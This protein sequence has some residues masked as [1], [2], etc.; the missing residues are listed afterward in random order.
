MEC[1]GKWQVG[2][3]YASW[4]KYESF[5]YVC[6]VC[7]TRAMDLQL[8]KRACF[9]VFEAKAIKSRTFS[10][11]ARLATVSVGQICVVFIH[12]KA[13][14]EG[15][16]KKCPRSFEWPA[17]CH[18]TLS[19]LTVAGHFLATVLR[20]RLRVC[21]QQSWSKAIIWRS[22][23]PKL[24]LGKVWEY[25][26]VH[27]LKM[28]CTSSSSISLQNTRWSYSHALSM[29]SFETLNTCQHPPFWLI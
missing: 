10:W 20:H 28:L 4:F 29:Q 23:K 13:D 12:D 19:C 8:L 5:W 2:R 27:T 26:L 7:V 9:H 22:C 21:V 1:G 3:W 11:F 15:F 25:E 16:F 24:C 18:C 14:K 6:N 17:T